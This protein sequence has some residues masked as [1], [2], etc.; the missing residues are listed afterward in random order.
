MKQEVITV[1]SCRH[2]FEI[3]IREIDIP[4][5]NEDSEIRKFTI[6]SSPTE[7]AS[8]RRSGV[9]SP[10]NRRIRPPLLEDCSN[11]FTDTSLPT[12]YRRS[13]LNF[14]S[15][16][17]IRPPLYEEYL[18]DFTDKKFL[19]IENDELISNE[20]I[21]HQ[22]HE[23]RM[24]YNSLNDYTTNTDMINFPWIDMG[25]DSRQSLLLSIPLP[26][27]DFNCDQL[28]RTDS[29]KMHAHQQ[30]PFDGDYYDDDFDDESRETAAPVRREELDVSTSTASNQSNLGAQYIKA[31]RNGSDTSCSMHHY[32]LDLLSSGDY[33]NDND[34]ESKSKADSNDINNNDDTVSH[35]NDDNDDIR[36][37]ND[38]NGKKK[39]SSNFYFP[40]NIKMDAINLYENNQ[41]HN[42]L[43]NDINDAV[44]DG[45]INLRGHEVE[46]YH[47]AD[48]NVNEKDR[49]LDGLMIGNSS[50]SSVTEQPTA[51]V[52]PTRCPSSSS[53]S[54]KR[55]RNIKSNESKVKRQIFPMAVSRNKQTVRKEV[56]MSY[57]KPA[58]S[59]NIVGASKRA[60]NKKRGEGYDFDFGSDSEEGN[61]SSVLITEIQGVE[62]KERERREDNLFRRTRG[63]EPLFAGLKALRL[64]TP[65]VKVKQSVLSGSVTNRMP[66]SLKKEQPKFKSA[67]LTD[68]TVVTISNSSV[69]V[70]KKEKIFPT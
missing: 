29:I 9:N 42:E 58:L 56:D 66:F 16:S 11:N 65:A 32:N 55:I 38:E 44:I 37:I 15:N 57:L 63:N 13:G 22:M 51:V 20:P 17:R 69:K 25:A 8:Y 31:N 26:I 40:N 61:G 36:D 1:N 21:N 19:S 70:K 14:P 41:K 53:S 3:T 49:S 30:E 35:R 47:N 12:T 4:D 60:E 33:I 52:I 54:S 64:T 39:C 2:R 68:K 34:N 59:K 46:E 5:T 7:P 48:L 45:N 10:L 67:N 50:W 6:T 23:S 28:D 43:Y 24:V 18:N 62:A 27:H